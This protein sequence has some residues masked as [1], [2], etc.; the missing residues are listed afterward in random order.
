MTP[1]DV[2]CSATGLVPD[3]RQLTSLLF[4]YLGIL[5]PERGPEKLKGPVR[6]PAVQYES[7]GFL[8]GGSV[9]QPFRGD[10]EAG[11]SPQQK[12]TQFPDLLGPRADGASAHTKAGFRGGE[13]GAGA[14]SENRP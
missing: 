9:F 1:H 7:R 13:G 12:T 14:I 8:P 4:F 10:S 11:P 3:R 6:G 2:A 5:K